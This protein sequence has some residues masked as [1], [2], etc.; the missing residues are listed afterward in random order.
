[1]VLLT[2]LPVVLAEKKLECT[3][4]EQTLYAVGLCVA[5]L[6]FFTTIGVSAERVSVDNIEAERVLD[7]EQDTADKGKESS[8]GERS[9]H[10]LD[11]EKSEGEG[12]VVHHKHI[13]MTIN[14]EDVATVPDVPELTG[15]V[16]GRPKEDVEQSK[17]L[18]VAISSVL[19][20]LLVWV[21]LGFLSACLDQD[22]S[23]INAFFVVICFMGV[24]TAMMFTCA[25][26]VVLR[27]QHKDKW[28]TVRRG[29]HVFIGVAILGLFITVGSLYIELG[30]PFPFKCLPGSFSDEHLWNNKCN[31]C[32]QGY[33]CPGGYSSKLDCPNGAYCV[34]GVERGTDCPAGF[35][36][37]TVNST[38]P[39]CWGECPEDTFSTGG[40]V[41]CGACPRSPAN[42][43]IEIFTGFQRKTQGFLFDA[44]SAP[45]VCSGHSCNHTTG[46]Q[47]QPGF[48][49]A[50][51]EFTSL[52][53]GVKLRSFKQRQAPE[54]SKSEQLC[55]GHAA[56]ET[57]PPPIFDSAV[58][59]YYAA[60]PY[61]DPAYAE[62]SP[63]LTANAS[64]EVDGP[65]G[66]QA[67]VTGEWSR[68]QKLALGVNPLS[69]Q[70]N[71]SDGKSS[72]T[73]T[74]NV[75]LKNSTVPELSSCNTVQNF[76][77]ALFPTFQSSVFTYELE[78]GTIPAVDLMPVA[79]ELGK[80][81]YK[82]IGNGFSQ[83]YAEV[84]STHPMKVDLS[85]NPPNGRECWVLVTAMDTVS[86]QKYVIKVKRTVA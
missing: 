21:F 86:T 8:G 72:T 52:L 30:S 10:E 40:Q 4:G 22:E 7:M 38:R 53:Q 15:V 84:N 23:H 65:S 20:A 64:S 77:K 25:V 27:V 11:K 37:G 69:V 75:E 26:R 79:K 9:E 34:A 82:C 18:L 33:Y 62:V 46:C 47:C 41:A 44:N 13:E 71:S 54:V 76:G 80:V 73:Y 58:T 55:A 60:V 12:G 67:T 61:S 17:T 83:V 2:W 74:I 68:I 78:L 56:C 85:D 81:T 1:L 32:P 48:S 24:V 5:I 6:G 45:A 29:C 43:E 31:P 57:A 35:Y 14:T 59:T 50:S 66:K 70:V 36:G 51:C 63:W 39:Q 16:S 19:F 49:G 3:S 28:D 42:V